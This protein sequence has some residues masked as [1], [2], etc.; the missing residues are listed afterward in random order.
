MTAQR[1]RGS[2]VL[3]ACCPVCACSRGVHPPVLLPLCDGGCRCSLNSCNEDAL[4]CAASLLFLGGLQ[5]T[6]SVLCHASLRCTHCV[7]TTSRRGSRLGNDK[8]LVRVLVA[9][10]GL[11]V[12]VMKQRETHDTHGRKHEAEADESTLRVTLAHEGR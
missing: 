5:E 7:R 8:P 6:S 9:L 12:H 3:E 10:N 2:R 11:A 1:R 4:L